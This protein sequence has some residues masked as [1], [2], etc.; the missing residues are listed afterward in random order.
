M[1]SYLMLINKLRVMDMVQWCLTSLSIIFQLYRLGQ[2]YW[3]RKPPEYPEKTTD[4]P[5]VTN[6]LYPLVSS[7]SSYHIMMYRK[8]V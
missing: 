6:K 8:Y 5:Q 3:W 4:R 1:I 7:N 2:F